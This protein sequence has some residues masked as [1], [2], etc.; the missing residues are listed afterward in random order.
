MSARP[1][2][3]RRFTDTMVLCGSLT[4]RSKRRLADLGAAARRDSE[5][6]KAGSRAGRIRQALGD[7]VAYR[8]DQ[9]VRR[10]E[11]DAD[12][13]RRWCGSGDAPG[14]EIC[15]SAMRQAS[16]DSSR[17]CSIRRQSARR[18]SARAPAAR[19]RGN[20]PSRR[21]AAPSWHRPRASLAHPAP[22][23]SAR[24]RRVAARRRGASRQSIC[25]I[26]KSAGIAVLSSASI[27]APFSSHR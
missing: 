20:R 23:Q 7:A 3:I 27:G 13:M 6:P 21:G 9:R 12:G 17:R 10:A 19:R 2:P 18:T 8:R 5:R 24:L 4:D 14:S 16:S 26:R 1:R 11:V 22:P 25:C 15:S